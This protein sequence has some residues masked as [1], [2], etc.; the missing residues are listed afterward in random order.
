M[1]PPPTQ[2]PRP[3][4]YVAA[5]GPKGLR[6]AARHAEGVVSLGEL[7]ATIDQS[8]VKFRERMS[9]LDERCAELGRDPASLRRCYFSGWGDEPIF[10]SPGATADFVGRFAEAGATEF[11]FT[12]YNPAQPRMAGGYERHEF[13]DR[14]MLERVAREVFPQFAQ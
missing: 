14:D 7:G 3:P 11:S 6:I 1:H 4:L 10:E 2:R 9:R 8:L 5:Q 13:A 12:L